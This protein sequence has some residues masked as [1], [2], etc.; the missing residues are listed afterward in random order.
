[1]HCFSSFESPT[2]HYMKV[3][4][5]V[6]LALGATSSACKYRRRRLIIDCTSSCDVCGVWV[7]SFLYTAAVPKVPP[8][9]HPARPVSVLILH[10][11][12]LV[13]QAENE[14]FYGH[15]FRV[16]VH[17]NAMFVRV[18]TP[19]IKKLGSIFYF[20]FQSI[21]RLPASIVGRNPSREP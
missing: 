18:Q 7:R 6:A 10:P 9:P 3:R 19:G 14:F 4:Y 16:L 5:F 2:Y 11:C 20:Q 8:R 1:M 12:L 15:I 17:G 13:T 21:L